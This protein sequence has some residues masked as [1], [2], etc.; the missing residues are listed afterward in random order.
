MRRQD[1]QRIF[2]D[3]WCE[4]GQIWSNPFGTQPILLLDIVANRLKWPTLRRVLRL[5]SNKMDCADAA[6]LNVNRP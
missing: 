2:N 5:A 1:M 4:S 3:E 6:I